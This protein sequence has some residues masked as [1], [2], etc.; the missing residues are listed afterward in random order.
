M[1]R[2]AI[3]AHADT[4]KGLIE[5]SYQN[6][7]ILKHHIIISTARTASLLEGTLNVPV[8]NLDHGRAGGYGQVQDL[9]ENGKIDI[10]M[11][12]GNPIPHDRKTSWYEQL[13]DT[14]IKNNVVVAYNQATIDM[15]LDALKTSTLPVAE[16]VH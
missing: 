13:A 1:K 15:L 9:L 10:L 11:F 7:N 6:K 16:Q 14:A 2:I 4:R 5:W 8:F 3:I 12:F